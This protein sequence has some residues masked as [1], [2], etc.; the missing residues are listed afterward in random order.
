[1]A[2]AEVLARLDILEDD[3][4][5]GLDAGALVYA[6]EADPRDDRYVSLLAL[7]VVHA[8]NLV[9][10]VEPTAVLENVVRRVLENRGLV[11]ADMGTGDRQGLKFEE[12]LLL[13]GKA[14][15]LSPT[16]KPRPRAAHA[17]DAGVD[18]LGTLLWPDRRLGQWIFVGQVT[19]GSSTTW[20]R[21][22]K[23]P[24]GETWRLYLQEALQPLPFLAVPHHID[25]RAWAY[26]MT[27]KI[28]LILDRLRMSPSKGANSYDERAL[29]NALLAA[30]PL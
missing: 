29:V 15:G 19:C 28:G 25:E 22:L 10:P 2:F 30:E 6:G 3:Y 23:E 14:C 24:E 12:N 8:W 21:K 20:K 9:R 4:P 17:K 5:F 7:T 26:L 27:P 13:Q 16:D 18:T 11:A 1:M